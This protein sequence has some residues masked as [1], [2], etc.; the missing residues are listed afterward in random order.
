[1]EYQPIKNSVNKY[2]ET[3]TSSANKRLCTMLK[4]FRAARDFSFLRR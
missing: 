1:M 4:S 2:T 3:Q